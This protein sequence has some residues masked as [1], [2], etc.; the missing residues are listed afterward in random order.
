L[1]PRM[2]ADARRYELLFWLSVFIC[3]H[4]WLVRVLK[5]ACICVRPRG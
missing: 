2:N 4:P 1:D 5:S 3:V